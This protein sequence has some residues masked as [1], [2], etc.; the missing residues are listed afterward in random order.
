MANDHPYPEKRRWS[1]AQAEIRAKISY[2]QQGTVQM[3]NGRTQDICEGGIALYVP[4]ELE[5]GARVELELTIPRSRAP[6]R[7]P[8]MIRDRIGFR[9]GME[10]LVINKAQRTEIANFV[11]LRKTLGN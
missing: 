11:E 1:R 4:I 10:F 3:S 6:L 2:Q 8:A 7:V 9:Y 5:L